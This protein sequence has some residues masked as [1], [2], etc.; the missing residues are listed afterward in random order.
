M[1]LESTRGKAVGN[2]C[3]LSCCW[4][5]DESD[6]GCVFRVRGYFDR[7]ARY[8]RD[9]GELLHILLLVIGMGFQYRFIVRHQRVVYVEDAEEVVFSLALLLEVGLVQ[10]VDGSWKGKMMFAEE[11]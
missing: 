10:H 2:E 1:L 4:I 8:R 11:S 7:R 6:C 9:L 5:K 3:W